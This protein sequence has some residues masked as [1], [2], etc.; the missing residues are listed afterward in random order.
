METRLMKVKKT[1]PNYHIN[2]LQSSHGVKIETIVKSNDSP[3]LKLPKWVGIIF[4]NDSIHI[5]LISI[6]MD[7]NCLYSSIGKALGITIIKLRKMVAQSIYLPENDSTIQF[8]RELHNLAV[9]EKNIELMTEYGHMKCIANIPL[10]RQITK[11]EK[12]LIYRE[13][14]KSS[15]WG[16]EYTIRILEKMLN[17]KVLV[18]NGDKTSLVKP[19]DH[20]GVYQHTYIMVYLKHN[21]YSLISYKKQTLFSHINLPIDIKNKIIV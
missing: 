12:K 18:V 4:P 19:L 21:H 20:E 8:W 5:S 16:E 1:T 14:M 17:I 9:K 7:G 3:R 15:F 2:L 11:Q 13:I 10:E 6:A